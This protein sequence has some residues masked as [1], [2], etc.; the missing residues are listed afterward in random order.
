ML[1]VTA[2]YPSTPTA[3]QVILGLT[4]LE[5]FINQ[6]A[7]ETFVRINKTLKQSWSG[8]G[9]GA[10][11]GHRWLLNKLAGEAGI[12]NL[13]YESKCGA[14]YI[15][16][17][18]NFVTYTS[19]NN[20]PEGNRLLLGAKKGWP[21][22]RWGFKVT[23]HETYHIKL[24][25]MEGSV[26]SWTGCT[27]ALEAACRY[28]ELNEIINLNVIIDNHVLYAIMRGVGCPGTIL[29]KCIDTLNK[30]SA[31][32][33]VSIWMD[34]NHNDGEWESLFKALDLATEHELTR[35][36]VPPKLK[37]HKTSIKEYYV[38]QWDLR[39]NNPRGKFNYRQTRLV[40][41]NVNLEASKNV[42]KLNREDLSKVIQLITG[43]GFNLYHQGLQGAVDDDEC[44]FCM[45]K[46]EEAHHILFTC[47][48]L[49]WLRS[50]VGLSGDHKLITHDISNLFLNPKAV[51]S[52]TRFISNQSVDLLFKPPGTE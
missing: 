4:P 46:P 44:R 9:H 21:D 52:L 29:H 22:I 19:G 12:E 6:R 50:Y 51:L 7:L 15:R 17:M 23:H 10:K 36:K 2:I 18:V 28:L 14:K 13:N 35:I 31:R 16:R 32:G 24:G 30:L 42:V 11:R 48:G 3:G 20:I 27:V 1:L 37:E 34:P 5:L 45:E 25:C 38:K 8:I 47:H 40:W 43:H 39:W 49:D 26:D 41:P 33:G